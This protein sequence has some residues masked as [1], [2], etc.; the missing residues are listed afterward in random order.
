MSIGDSIIV[1]RVY[2]SCLVVIGG[3]E[4]RV[5]LLLLNTVDLDVTLCMD[6]LSPYHGIMDYHA[7]IVA[8]AMLGLPWLECSPTLNYISSRVVSFLKVHRIVEKGCEAYLAFVRDVSADTHSVELILVL[9]DF[10]YV[11]LP[12]LPV[13][14]PH[15]DIDFGIDLVPGS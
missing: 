4:T 7:M 11:I 12:D 15:R 14:L 13:M 3:F 2:R 8:L 10:P 5:D 1:D 9:R 6:W